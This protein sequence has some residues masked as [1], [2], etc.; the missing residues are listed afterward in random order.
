MM[1]CWNWLKWKFVS[2][3]SKYEYPGDD[4]PI[5]PGSA[6][7]ALEDRDPT[8]GTESIAKLMAAVDEYIPTPTR[9]VDQP[10]LDAN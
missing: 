2:C 10:F 8:I 7:A 1:S 3:L 4:I 5:I 9:A 6:L